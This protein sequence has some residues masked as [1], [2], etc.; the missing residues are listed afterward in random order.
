MNVGPHFLL[1]LG[2]TGLRAWAATHPPA[3]SDQ[4]LIV[5]SSG[6]PAYEEVLDSLRKGVSQPGVYVLDLR[7]KD[8]EQILNEALRLKTVRIAITIGG[9]A[10][11]AVM[12]Q[13]AGAPFIA[14]VIAP[15][16]L[17]KDPRAGGKPVSFIP[18]QVPLAT[19]LESVK[20]VFPNKLRLGM[21]RNAALQDG[22]PD[23]LKSTAWAAGFSVRIVD[24][25]GPAQLLQ[26]FQSLKDQ[27]DLVLCFPDATLYNSATIK[28]LVLAS[29]RHRLPLIGFSESFV[30]AGAALGVYPD[31]HD[32]GTRG[33]ELIQKVLN[34][35]AVA[36]VEHPRK[37]RIAVNLNITRLLG[38]G[39]SQP[40]GAGEDFVVIR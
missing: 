26:V 14:T 16:L 6:V 8:A 13:H 3:S 34:G 12:A 5:T 28:P 37:F 10:A 22:G 32:V 23:N 18:V 2:L 35:Q 40:P 30:R 19:L 7:Q 21:I 11:E 4:V 24:C 39:Y 36:K 38:L 1:L 17:P 9:E 29:L 31:F 15:Y 20:R 25:Q 33:A 27:V